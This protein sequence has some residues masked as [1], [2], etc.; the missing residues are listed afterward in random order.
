MVPGLRTKDLRQKK[1][2]FVKEC[3]GIRAIDTRALCKPPGRE[4]TMVAPAQGRGGHIVMASWMSIVHAFERE[5]PS[6]LNGS[7]WSAGSSNFWSLD[8]HFG[9]PQ[10]LAEMV[11]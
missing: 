4:C 1:G 8:T 3:V 9:I 10:P 5:S 7:A 6:I 11:E 2:A